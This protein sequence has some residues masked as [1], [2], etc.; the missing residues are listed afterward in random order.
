MPNIGTSLGTHLL[1]ALLYFL[2]NSRQVVYVELSIKTI[3]ILPPPLLLSS[4]LAPL[5]HRYCRHCHFCCS[6]LIVVCPRRCHCRRL[7]CRRRRLTADPL[8]TVVV[9]IVIIVTVAIVVVVIVIVVPVAAINNDAMP[10]PRCSLCCQSLPSLLSRCFLRRH[11]RCLRCPTASASAVDVVSVSAAAATYQPPWSW[12]VALQKSILVDILL[13][14]KTI[15]V[16]R[17]ASMVR[18]REHLSAYLRICVSACQQN[19]KKI[20][21]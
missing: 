15:L 10:G 2:P 12:S 13:N 8:P 14:K 6:L 17:H 1:D 18:R 21:K 4:C 20:K 16:R 19:H 9:M 5:A 11:C 3:H 7:C